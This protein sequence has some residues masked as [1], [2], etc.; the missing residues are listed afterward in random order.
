[1]PLLRTWLIAALFSLIASVSTGAG[2]R[3]GR[4][5][6]VAEPGI[7]DYLEYGG[8]GVLVYDID[9]DHRFL[10][11]IATAGVDGKGK[12]MNVKGIA[13]SIPL[14]RLFVTTIKSLM[15]IDLVTEKLLWEKSY[16]GG[17]D[18]LAISPN[19]KTLY[20][21]SLEA[22]HWNVINAANGKLIHK[23]ITNS[24]AHNT[25]F[26][27]N[28]REVYMAGLK[29]PFLFISSASD[30]SILGKVGPFAAPIRPF[31]INGSQT[32]CYVNVND[33]LG[34]EIGDLNS[35]RK[36]ARVEIE[37]Y[38]KGPTKRHGCPSHGIGLTP[39]EREIWVSDAANSRLHVFDNT[40]MPPRQTDS[41]TLRDQPGWITFTIAG[42]FAY[43]STCDVIDTKNHRVVTVLKD[44]K[45][46][47]I[48]SEKLLEIDFEKGRPI[49]AGDQFGIGRKN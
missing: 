47:P 37:G 9:H 49:R 45:G 23:I 13:V 48:Q 7:R 31:T 44:E 39:D 1:M 2:E 17:C 8:H 29:S 40:V 46:S 36:L 28:G 32:R 10:K 41:I 25:I 27:P 14:Q 3:S 20:V 22:N 30:Y 18:R 15:A 33:L 16:E 24:G 42:D 38:Q 4:F 43:P 6:Y 19:G 34:F 21:P 5:L 12:P 35:G 26:G 11:R